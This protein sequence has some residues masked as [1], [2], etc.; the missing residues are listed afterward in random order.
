[1]AWYN[2]EHRHRGVR[3]VTPYQRRDGRDNEILANRVRV[4]E[5]ARRRHPNRWSRGIR[6]S[7]PAFFLSPKRDHETIEGALSRATS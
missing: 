1:M 6:N 7:A 2:A 5:R 3:F 4:C